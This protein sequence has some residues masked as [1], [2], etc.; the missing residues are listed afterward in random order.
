MIINEAHNGMIRCVRTRETGLRILPRAHAAGVRY[1][2]LEALSS[3]FAEQANRTRRLPQSGGYLGQADMRD[4]IRAAL[5]LGWTLVPY[6]ADSSKQPTFE[7]PA[8]MKATNWREHE[9]ANN[10]AAA[11]DALGP[12][13][14]L[15]VWCGNSH[16]EKRAIGDWKP[17]ANQFLEI[18]GIEPFS[19]DQTL[20]LASEG[21]GD[22]RGLQLLEKFRKQLQATASETLGFLRED[23]DEGSDRMGVDAFVLSLRNA[24]E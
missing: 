7:D 14:P 16:L 6:E 2:A 4:L 10:L 24:M 3:S 19:I 20:S 15:L 17:M 9:Q 8:G 11:V 13:A 18:S 22:R 1:F 23:W 12:D 21:S 5:D